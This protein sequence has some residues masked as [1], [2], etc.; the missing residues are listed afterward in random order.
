MRCV[1]NVALRIFQSWS[2][3]LATWTT[4]AS[5]PKMCPGDDMGLS[6]NRLNHYTQWFCWSL[7]LWKMAISLGIY[8]IFRQTHMNYGSLT[9]DKFD[10]VF[11]CKKCC[12]NSKLHQWCA[13][14][15]TASVLRSLK[16]GQ[17]WNIFSAGKIAGS[18]VTWQPS[19]II[20][21]RATRNGEWL[22]MNVGQFSCWLR[23]FIRPWWRQY[24]PVLSAS[25]LSFRKLH[26]LLL[27]IELGKATGCDAAE[28]RQAI[29]RH[30]GAA[31]SDKEVDS[32]TWQK[33]CPLY[34]F[35]L[36]FLW[37]KFGVV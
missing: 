5:Y 14:W 16:W 32:A 31:V 26:D 25:R 18:L 23:Q 24:C 21:R 27:K 17:W 10:L 34:S 20:S 8:L 29:W 22:S 6:E 12:S 11:W 35:M 9:S 15:S 7:S 2:W 19:A 28:A 30:F 33:I 4:V 37:S 13:T 1:G 36:F 3:A